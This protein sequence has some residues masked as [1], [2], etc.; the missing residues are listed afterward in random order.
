MINW[1]KNLFTFID[2]TF[3]AVRSPAWPNF[4][5][6]YIKKECEVCGKKYFLELHHI[7][8]FWQH[9]ELELFPSNV[10]TLCRTHHLEWG[11]YFSWASWNDR[12]K[13]DIE[14][15]KNKP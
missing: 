6:T 2:H 4:R 11:H 14:R 8:P 13:E 3:G 9:P 1:I 10:V 5:K 12:I 7:I 15:I